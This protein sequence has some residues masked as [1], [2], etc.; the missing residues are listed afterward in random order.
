MDKLKYKKIKEEEGQ[1]AAE[2]YRLQCLMESV[3]TFVS[4]NSDDLDNLL[5]CGQV[6][7]HC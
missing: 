3:E 2:N 1:D 6:K 7:G 4:N 5:M